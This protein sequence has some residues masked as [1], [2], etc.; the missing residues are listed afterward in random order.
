MPEN[1]AFLDDWHKRKVT[2]NNPFSSN[3]AYTRYGLYDNEASG[4]HTWSLEVSSR[5]KLHWA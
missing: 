1:K 5:I 4:C 2:R 3:L